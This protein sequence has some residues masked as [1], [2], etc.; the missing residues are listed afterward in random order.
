MDPTLRYAIL[1]TCMFIIGLIPFYVIRIY[2]FTVKSHFLLSK[3]AQRMSLVTNLLSFI[4]FLGLLTFYTSVS[5]FLSPSFYAIMILTFLLI[6]LIYKRLDMRPLDHTY[7]VS[8][9]QIGSRE[10]L[11][12]NISSNNKL[13]VTTKSTFSFLTHVKYFSLNEEEIEE[14][15]SELKGIEH[16]YLSFTGI[17]AHILFALYVLLLSFSFVSFIVFFNVL[18]V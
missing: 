1:I 12:E 7:I 8:Y 18:I 10:R 14:V 4:L 3:T 16:V 9:T 2:M 6:L 17:I 13:H 15:A 11:V 5:G